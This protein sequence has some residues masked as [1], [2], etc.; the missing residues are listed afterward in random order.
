MGV[1]VRKEWNKKLGRR[2]EWRKEVQKK[3][4]SFFRGYRSLLSL[5]PRYA[6]FFLVPPFP[7][8]ALVSPSLSLSSFQSHA[9]SATRHLFTYF[10]ATNIISLFHTL[11]L[12]KLHSYPYSR[13]LKTF[14][15]IAAA[16]K[17]L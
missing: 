13:S 9:S 15:H 12:I 16:V 6:T 7:W 8:V 11:I 14:I 10:L 17:H 2:E 1:E 3:I 4:F 5:K